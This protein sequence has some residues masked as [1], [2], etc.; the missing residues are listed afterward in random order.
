MWHFPV[1]KTYVKLRERIFWNEI[2]RLLL[3]CSRIAHNQ[4]GS[5]KFVMGGGGLKT[6]NY[7]YVSFFPF[8]LCPV[9]RVG[10]GGGSDLSGW[11]EHVG[12]YFSLA[13]RFLGLSGG[14]S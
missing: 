6:I 2:H 13:A 8:S 7:N 14:L 4:L 5:Q 3:T 11:S 10:G 1:H 12:P 9:N